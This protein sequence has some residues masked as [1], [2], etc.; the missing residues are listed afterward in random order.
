VDKKR[1]I[2]RG[3]DIKRYSYEWAGQYLI[4]T[5]NGIPEKGIPKID[6][7]KYHAVKKHLDF[8]WEKIESRADQGD[9]P[10][11]LRSCAYTDVSNQQINKSTI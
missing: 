3:R 8:Y 6:I 1:P 9:T 11:H 10:Y 4:A 2:L 5:H 7:G